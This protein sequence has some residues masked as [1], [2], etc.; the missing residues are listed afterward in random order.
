MSAARSA[1][2]LDRHR[3]RPRP[4]RR[5]RARGAFQPAGASDAEPRTSRSRCGSATSRTSPTPG[6]RRRRGGHLRGRARRG[7]QPRARRRSTPGTHAIEALFADAID[8]TYIGPNPAINGVRAVRRRSAPDRLRRDV[9][10]RVPRREAG[11]HEAEGP[12]GQ[13]ASRRRQLGNTQDV[14]LRAWLKTKGSRPTP[15]AAATCRSSRRT[16]RSRSTAFQAGDIDGAWVPEPW[17]TRLIHEGGGKVLVDER[18]LWPDG[19]YV[20]THLIVRKPFLDEHPRRRAG[21]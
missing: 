15:R 20:T 18:D 3:R 5:A 10:R 14:A 4:R 6:D 16:T 19:E 2:A 1:G 7:R 8:A 17:A 11:D 13:D 9:R 12:E 21:A